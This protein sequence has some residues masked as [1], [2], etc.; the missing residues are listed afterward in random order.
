ME[1]QLAAAVLELGQGAWWR[2]PVRRWQSRN[3]AAATARALVI[4]RE[5]EL[6][7]VR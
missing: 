2:S 3:S 4:M 7:H 1:S 5:K 6:F